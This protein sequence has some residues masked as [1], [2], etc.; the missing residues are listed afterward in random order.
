M[1]IK[2]INKLLNLNL[3]NKSITS[4]EDLYK[5]AEILGFNIDYIGFGYNFP[6]IEKDC[7]LCILNLGNDIIG[8][9]HWVAVNTK[10][11]EYFDPLGLPP[12]NYIPKDYTY[13]KET[14]QNPKF[15][16][17]GQYSILFLYYSNLGKSDEFYKLFAEPLTGGVIELHNGL[18]KPLKKRKNRL[19]LPSILT[20]NIFTDLQKERFEKQTLPPIKQTLPPIKKEVSF[21]LTPEQLAYQEAKIREARKGIDYG[22]KT[23]KYDTRFDYNLGYRRF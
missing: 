10:T 15:G 12:D 1:K 4:S 11:K 19:R 7:K 6:D 16:R 8:G 17:C 13:N 20:S 2:N 5:L 9:S 22:E 18:Y 21:K 3:I 14:I 23:G